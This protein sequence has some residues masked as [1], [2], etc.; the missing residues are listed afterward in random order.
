MKIIIGGDLV[1]TENNINEF[2]NANIDNLMDKKLQ[3]KWF[4]ADYRIF[5]LETP[6]VNEKSP[7]LKSGPHLSASKDSINGLKELN[8]SL[9]SM[10]NNHIMDHGNNGLTSTIKLMK[11]NNLPYTGVGNNLESACKS[12]IINEED[13]KIGVYSCAEHEFTIA[14]EKK[15][16][17]N[18][19]DPFESLDHISELSKKSDFVIVLY[20]G[21]KEHYRYPTPKVEK[22]CKKMVDKGAD[23]VLCQHSHCIGSFEEYDSGTILYGQGNFIFNM[24][25]NEY[26]NTGLLVELVIKKDKYNMDYIPF[27]TNSVGIQS[28]N[29]EEKHEIMDSFNKRSE[30]IKNQDFVENEY[31]KFVHK[32]IDNYLRNMTFFGKWLSRIDRM[33]FNNFFLNKIFNKKKLLFLLN[34]FQCEAHRELII[35]GIKE[36]IDINR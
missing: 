24:R 20:H 27:K 6:L 33:I 29:N 35:K 14:T 31:N 32:N 30:E 34:A 7:I 28:L 4:D 11:K 36:K 5:N 21:L 17:A 18:P 16:G 10:A 25:D 26:W 1:P 13:L 8:P 23:L 15:P 19:F 22:A 9:I 2:E 12:Y 3:K